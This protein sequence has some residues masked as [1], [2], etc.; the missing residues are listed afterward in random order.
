MAQGI[1]RL[2]T[3]VAVLLCLIP[4]IM[5]TTSWLINRDALREAVQDQ[6]RDVTGLEV[7][8]GG[9]VEVSL[10]PAAYASFH[11]IDLKGPDGDSASTLHVEVLKAKLHLL[12][13]L[14]QRFEISDLLLSEP[15]IRVTMKPNGE[16]NWTPFIETVAR[17]MKPDAV[18]QP[19]FSEIRIANGVLDY[20]DAKGHIETFQDINLALAWPSISR[21]FAATGQFDWRDERVD[22]SISF[23]NFAA[24]LVGDRSGVKARISSAPL[25]MAFDGN[26]ANHASPILGGMLTIDSPSL[27]NALR[28]LGQPPP[29]SSGFGRFTLK[30]R[31]DL[32]G[33]SVA[34]TNVNVELDGNAA[35]GVMSYSNNNRRMLQATLAADALDFTP[36]IST[37]RLLATGAHDWNRQLFDLNGLSATDLD[38]RLSAAQLTIGASKLGRTALGANLHN[39]TLAL[40]VGEAQVYGGIAHGSLV[41]A[42]SSAN[43]D[44]KAQLQFK[45]VDLKESASEWFRIG[46]LAGRGNINVTLS[47]SGSSPFDL[48]QTLNGSATINGHD[49]RILGIDVGQTLKRLEQR[50]L[51]PPRLDGGTTAFDDLVIAVRFADGIATTD[52][53]HI[54]GPTARITLS[55]TISVPLREYD[56]DGVASLTS[57]S[58]FELKFKLQGPWD[59]PTIFPDAES[60][61]RRSKASKQLLDALKDPKTQDAVRSAIENL[62]A[63][64]GSET[65]PPDDDKP[66]ASDTPSH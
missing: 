27:R 63:K 42:R 58:D 14:L 33:G 66:A 26:I 50:P 61:L 62:I 57:A 9:T 28:W 54:E 32:V 16:S 36:Y 11:N 56:L 37:F 46:R 23:S 29:A 8:V 2:G 52:D 60:L 31:A 51:S 65:K 15:H 3:P 13:L 10:F 6:I 20:Q 19:S 40:S 45:D 17:T 47:A 53:I 5:V 38:M 12:P 24:I 39:G 44:I 21:S 59:D 41:I 4:A 30:A 7:N 48:V 1:K 35:E 22:G 34:L 25:K 49:G 55:G 18:N 64:P 43:V